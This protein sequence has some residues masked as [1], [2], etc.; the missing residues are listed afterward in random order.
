VTETYELDSRTSV[1]F[2]TGKQYK[3]SLINFNGARQ[4]VREDV[5][6]YFGLDAEAV[7]DM[8]DFEIRMAADEIAQGVS[9][10]ASKLGGKVL[11]SK[12]AS[13]SESESERTTS[14]NDPWASVEGSTTSAPAEEPKVE[15]DP[16]KA[17]R[18]TIESMQDV[19]GLQRLW[20]ENRPLFDAN[21]D[22]M[23][24]YKAR[25]KHLQGGGK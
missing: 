24:A 1:T 13:S 5:I 16:L 22:L 17:M 6:A 20:A 3:E 15:E 14:G 23:V 4:A 11:G 8:T 7:K 19:P 2:K 25:G 12:P 9:T 10:V 21:A 18:D